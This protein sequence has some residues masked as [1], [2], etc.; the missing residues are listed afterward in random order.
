MLILDGGWAGYELSIHVPRT[1][2]AYDLHAVGCL[3]PK[4]LENY[5]SIPTNR[6]SIKIIFFCIY[7]D[8]FLN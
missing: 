5:N 8:F 6:K 7:L 2:A 4:R 1:V 3:D